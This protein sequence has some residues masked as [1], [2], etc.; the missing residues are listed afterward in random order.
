M[1]A[2]TYNLGKSPISRYIHV[3]DVDVT[4]QLTH[5]C[6]L[7]MQSCWNQWD[8]IMNTDFSQ[9]KLIYSTSDGVLRF[10][11]NSTTNTK[12]FANS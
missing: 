3:H 10:L 4:Q 6:S 5:L 9:N 2:N 11:L 7:Q 1:Y 8:N 12:Y